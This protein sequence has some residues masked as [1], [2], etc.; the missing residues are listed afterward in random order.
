MIAFEKDAG[1]DLKES[2]GNVIGN[3][4]EGDICNTG[5]EILTVPLPVA[6]WKSRKRT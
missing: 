3:W 4:R 1:K 5:A 2:G 6:T